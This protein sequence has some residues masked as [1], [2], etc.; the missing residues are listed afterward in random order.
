MPSSN[1]S[2]PL[3]RLTKTSMQYWTHSSLSRR[4]NVQPH[5]AR[6]RF[7]GYGARSVWFSLS[8]WLCVILAARVRARVLCPC[9]VHRSS[10]FGNLPARDRD[11]APDRLAGLLMGAGIYLHLTERH[12]HEQSHAAMEHEH[13]HVHDAHHQHQHL[14]RSPWRAAQPSAPA[15][16]PRTQP[17]ALSRPASSPSP[18]VRHANLMLIEPTDR[19]SCAYP[20]PHFHPLP[21]NRVDAFFG[22]DRNHRDTRNRISPPPT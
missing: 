13:R 6:C 16:A 7:W 2:A 4:Q 11:I 14:P 22:D 21:P 17:P 3:M 20:H 10:D 1:A 12:E 15:R 9:A 19:H 5:E 8:S 18:R